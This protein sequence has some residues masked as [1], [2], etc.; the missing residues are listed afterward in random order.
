MAGLIDIAKGAYKGAQEAAGKAKPKDG[1]Q[2]SKASN[3]EHVQ[4][5]MNTLTKYQQ[6]KSLSDDRLI[7]NDR[8]Y[9]SQQWDIMREKAGKNKNAAEPE[10]TTNLVWNTVANKQGD[11]MDAFPEPIFMEREPSD[12]EDAEQLSKVVKYVLERNKFRK[13]Y[14]DCAWY[15]VKSGT[16]CY[17]VAWDQSL[18]GGLGDISIKKVDLL[19]LYWQ[20][21][22]DNIQDS[23]YVFALSLMD[24]D[25][26]ERRYP[27]LEGKV[28]ARYGIDLKK[29]NELDSVDTEGMVVVVDC[30]YKE[31]QQDGSTI[32]HMDKIVGDQ[33]VDSTK[34][35]GQG[36]YDHG[37]YPFV[38]DTMFPEEHSLLGF[39]MVD[40]IK[41]T[42]MYIDK[43]D[44]ILTRN[45]LVSGRQRMLFK[46]GLF[47]VEEAADLSL[48]FIACNGYLKAG[49]DYAILQ[50]N[51]LPSSI[52]EHRN[53]KIAELKEVSGANDFSRGAATGGVTSATAILALQ[54]AGN[55]LSRAIVSATYDAYVDICNMALELIIQFYDE[56]RKFRITNAQGEPEY[57]EFSNQGLKE[58]P[59]AI[60][61]VE[62][63]ETRKPIY[64]IVCHAEKYSPF[65]AIANNEIAK[66]LFGMGFFSPEMA[67][68]ALTALKLMS[69]DGKDRLEK[70]IQET[71]QQQ[72]EMQQAT[73]EAQQA[74][75]QQEEMLVMMNDYIM[76]LT[77][78]NMLD[79]STVGQQKQSGFNIAAEMLPEGQVMP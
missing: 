50:A 56:P 75:A 60:D 69:F 52:M 10:P 35:K 71:Y 17:H 19:R 57:V 32:L 15:K 67:P 64:D 79:G 8:W 27:Q 11:L 41:N 65:S 78:E 44:Q 9:R 42:Q 72:M 40:V 53:M 51:P 45:A 3:R 38:F 39:G 14:S 70:S 49:E 6:G 68:A 25:D 36:L 77:G 74:V 20:P 18:E 16:A 13:T 46:K 55:K 23:K 22:V 62:T 63:A 37:L 24:K 34:D 43:L 4:K 7:E 61:G 76:Q 29:Y 21:G 48:D 59:I 1:S 73:N 5:L 58:K 30:Y 12:R 54:E 28:E 33:V 47:P 2:R 66:E 31:L 26:A